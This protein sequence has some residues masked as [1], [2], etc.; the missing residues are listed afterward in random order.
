MNHFFSFFTT[1]C[2]LITSL[3]YTQQL[4]DKE[5]CKLMK[6]KNI[7]WVE[8]FGEPMALLQLKKGKKWGMYRI[9]TSSYDEN[10]TKKDFSFEEIIPAKFDSIGLFDE[11]DQFTIVKNEDKYGLFL[12]PFEIRDADKKATCKYDA[13]KIITDS[14][15]LN[16]DKCVLVKQNNRWGLIDWF[17]DYVIVPITYAN[18]EDVP[19]TYMETWEVD[20]LKHI[21]RKLKLSLVEFDKGNGDG[22]FKGQNRQ[23]KWGMYQGYEGNYK[24]LIPAIYD[25]IE[26][27][28]FNGNFTLVYQN[29]KL[30]IYLSPWS[31][32]DAKQTIPCTY[33]AYKTHTVHRFNGSSS[34][35]LALQKDGKWGWVNWLTGNTEIAFEYNSFEELPYPSYK[36][37]YYLEN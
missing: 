21:R 10:W 18:A 17:S 30:G 4:P 29:N 15:S 6:A 36:Q 25:N 2:L 14:I 12:N 35:Y 16:M 28:G 22:V 34:T 31:Y 20:E 5:I 23:G 26:F 7:T 27:F 32:D 11:Y 3:G 9:E 13:I 8:S 33:D 24:E 1:L 37:P 19:L